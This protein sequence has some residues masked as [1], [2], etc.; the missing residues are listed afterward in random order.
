MITNRQSGTCVDE[1]AA[2]IFRVSTPVD[3]P[4]GTAFSFNPCLLVDDDSLL[5]HTGPR[6]VFGLVREA[7]GA[8]MPIER[9]RYVA[10]SHVEA[11]E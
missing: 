8:I 9:L 10:F 1:V 7:I 3:L 5:F 2:G 6:Q 11:D 4:D